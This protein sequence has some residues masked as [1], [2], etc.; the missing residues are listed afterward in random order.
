MAREK[1]G[2]IQAICLDL[3]QNLVIKFERSTKNKKEEK[4]K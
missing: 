3:F 2:A 4:V 1:K